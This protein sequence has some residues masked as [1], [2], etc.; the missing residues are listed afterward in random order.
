MKS[1]LRICFKA[2]LAL[3]V[4]ASTAGVFAQPSQGDVV[5]RPVP[6]VS[7]YRVQVRNRGGAVRVDRTTP[8]PAVNLDLPDGRY[9]VRVAPL[10]SNGRP[11]VWSN[12]RPLQII[13]A[14]KPVVRRESDKPIV[15]NRGQTAARINVEGRNFGEQTRATLENG[16]D[17]L[18]VRGLRAD[19]TGEKLELEVDLRNARPGSYDLVVTNPPGRREVAQDFLV[20]QDNRDWSAASFAEYRAYVLSLTRD[21]RS[22]PAPTMIVDECRQQFVTLNLKNRDRLDVFYFLKLTGGNVNDR[23]DAY[24]YYAERCPPPFRPAREFMEARLDN[25]ENHPG[26]NEERRILQSI[27]K[28]NACR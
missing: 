2:T 23:M 19:Q 10:D 14:G 25:R 18:P 22:S 12:W 8:R 16:A 27:A 1:V 20:V 15:V 13:S 6:G 24:S 26:F 9:E 5:W 17:R 3:G 11:A 7:Q 28:M 4:L 21:C